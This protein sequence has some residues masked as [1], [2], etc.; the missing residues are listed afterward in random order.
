M[1]SF[2]AA[3]KGAGMHVVLG[4]TPLTIPREA[5]RDR[6]RRPVAHVTYEIHVRPVEGKVGLC[7]V[8]ETPAGPTV[9]VVTLLAGRPQPPEVDIVS[10]VAADA[11]D[12]GI[13][14]SRRG[15]ALLASRHRVKTQQRK[16]RQIV[17]EEDVRPP[18]PFVV[19]L[20][21]SG[22]FLPP[23]DIVRPV[24][25]IAASVQR[26]LIQGSRV[27]AL[28]SDVAVCT[29]KRKLRRSIVVEDLRCPSGCDVASLAIRS[30]A[31]VMLVVRSVA[32]DAIGGELLLEDPA[33]M[34]RLAGG[35]E[36]AAR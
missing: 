10:L 29:P 3:T 36:V 34:T 13:L 11:G 15:V 30:V 32:A 35:R 27:A 26:L 17:I 4:V 9:R 25:G 6:V 31:P 1:A 22:S 18:L 14:E 24:A 20:L 8:I 21:A 2:A 5:D 28:A 12:L 19:A 16:P 33:R 7:A 23:V